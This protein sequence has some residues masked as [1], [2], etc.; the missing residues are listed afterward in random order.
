VAIDLS[1]GLGATGIE[2]LSSR[3]D[4]GSVLEAK[5]S[6]TAEGRFLFAENRI[7]LLR[8]AVRSVGFPRS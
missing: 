1:W 7:V 3:E 4:D 8:D 6:V 2:L 5:L